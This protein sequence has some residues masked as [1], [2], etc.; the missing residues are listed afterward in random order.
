MS[1]SLSAFAFVRNLIV[2]EV[3]ENVTAL[4]VR[5]NVVDVE[6]L[7]LEQTLKFASVIAVSKLTV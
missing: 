1:E 6:S 3:V 7:P 2:V 5:G 4:D